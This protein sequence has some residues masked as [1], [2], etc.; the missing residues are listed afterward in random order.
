M[1]N[2]TL[3]L[4]IVLCSLM[5]IIIK[6]L[7]EIIILIKFQKWPN[8]R[9]NPT[10]GDLIIKN[11]FLKII[12][13]YLIQLI[14][15]EFFMNMYIRT[16]IDSIIY[17]NYNFV[18]LIIIYFINVK[19]MDLVIRVIRADTAMDDICIINFSLS[20]RYLV[21]VLIIILPIGPVALLINFVLFYK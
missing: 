14:I 8:T 18:L 19:L 17:H 20:I 13:N 16:I 3:L 5:A 11:Y 4:I 7:Q 12:Y 9:T 15:I 1:N 2:T 10:P 21:F 6:G